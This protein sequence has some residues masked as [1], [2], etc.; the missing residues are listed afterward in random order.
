MIIDHI[1][2]QTAKVVTTTTDKHGDQIAGDSIIVN[3]RFR[4]YTAIDR[5]VSAE[6][7]LGNNAIIWFNPSTAVEE[8][9]I[10]QVDDKYWRIDKLVKARRMGATVEFLK[11]YVKKH[12]L[13]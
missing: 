9:S 7:L 2:N 10:I 12:D 13:V 11:A 4:Y 1:L 5:G 8:G 6:D 3:C